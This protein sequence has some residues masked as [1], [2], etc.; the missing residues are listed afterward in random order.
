[1]RFFKYLI[2]FFFITITNAHAECEPDIHGVFESNLDDP[3]YRICAH[4]PSFGDTRCIMEA[5]T[6]EKTGNTYQIFAKTT[7]E[8]CFTETQLNKA[9][10]YECTE[11]VCPVTEAQP[12]PV[13]YSKGYYNSE[14]SCVRSQPDD[15]VLQCT[16]EYCANPDN[17]TCPIG[18]VSGKVNNIPHCVKSGEPNPDPDPEECEVDCDNELNDVQGI[19]NSINNAGNNITESLSDLL[20]DLNDGLSLIAD[21]L[22]D[23]I[24]NQD[25]NSNNNNNTGCET[26]CDD[27]SG[28]DTSGLNADVPYIQLEEKQLDQ[29]IFAS[30]AS[31]PADNTLSMQLGNRSFSYTFKYQ[32][33]CN[34]LE[35]LGFFILAFAYMFA[36]NIVVKA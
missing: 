20:S 34:G 32:P 14:L 9:T 5:Y 26:D 22:Q 4:G 13:G 2:L 36:A 27:G 1:M 7:G 17:K 15:N 3:P 16:V 30:S 24:S 21:K 35:I 18:Y 31:C 33:I 28:V 29:N 11:D 25:N 8:S 10:E 19:I 12:C 6:M 23:I